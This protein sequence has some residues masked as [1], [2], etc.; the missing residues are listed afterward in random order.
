ME[1]AD[2]SIVEVQIL[3]LA[4]KFESQAT[5]GSG[6]ITPSQV[7]EKITMDSEGKCDS[8]ILDAF[9]KAFVQKTMSAAN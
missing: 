7:A 1:R 9:V 8:M 5:A 3:N 2:D 6:K 4:E